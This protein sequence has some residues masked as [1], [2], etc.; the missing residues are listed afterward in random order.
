MR[1]S[2][3]AILFSMLAMACGGSKGGTGPTP[4]GDFTLAAAPSALTLL[5]G[6]DGYLLVTL[7]ASSGFSAPVTL[8][9]SGLPAGASAVPVT[10]AP[11]QTTAALRV[12]GGSTLANA[13]AMTVTAAGGGR[14]HSAVVAVSVTPAPTGGS[15]PVLTGMV[16]LDVA[17]STPTGF[18][19]PTGIAVNPANGKVYMVSDQAGGLA[20]Y[21][22]AANTLGVV[23]IPSAQ[24]VAVSSAT[25]TVYA[26]G[27]TA[28]LIVVEGGTASQVV[29]G[30][31]LQGVAVDSSTGQVFVAENLNHTVYQIDGASLRVKPATWRFSSAADGPVEGPIAVDEV[32][33]TVYASLYG[34]IGVISQANGDWFTVGISRVNST[35]TQ[36]PVDMSVDP[37]N[38][39]AYIL[40]SDGFNGSDGWI[41]LLDDSYLPDST[42][43]TATNAPSSLA[44][45]PGTNKLY[46]A[47]SRN[48]S[49]NVIDLDSGAF[50]KMVQVPPSGGLDD[51]PIGVAVDPVTHQ[52]FATFRDYG[53]V[54]ALAV[55][56]GR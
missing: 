37:R 20:V 38:G 53:G 39:Q 44:V 3:P 4:T 6:E 21:D 24:R 33:H 26:V 18:A 28:N 49:V 35:L 29:V 56:D 36:S 43:A 46:V 2:L 51:G 7:T 12:H 9:A 27:G 10:M 40:G 50:M 47:D 32:R 41:H 16:G 13:A 15:D 48:Q 34:G 23:P 8:T 30:G 54:P 1:P 5:Q 55:I 17:G 52:V 19:N 45:D 11:G 42:S 14:S 25:D 31:A 22:P